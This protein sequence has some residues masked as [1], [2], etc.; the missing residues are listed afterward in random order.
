MPSNF[1]AEPYKVVSKKRN[2]VT[3]RTCYLRKVTYNYVKKYR[4]PIT[5]YNAWE[6]N[7]VTCTAEYSESDNSERVPDVSVNSCPVR[8]WKL[9]SKFD[10]F[11]M[12]K[13]ACDASGEKWKLI[14]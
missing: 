6:P 8:T 1:D 7:D 4:E 9:S 11:I 14:A 12:A 13:C 3:V 10:N 5:D 2:N